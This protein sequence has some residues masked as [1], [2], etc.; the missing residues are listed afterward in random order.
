MYILSMVPL[1]VSVCREPRRVTFTACDAKSP[2][3]NAQQTVLNA[4]YKLRTN[5]IKNKEKNVRRRLSWSR[6]T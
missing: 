4:F 6:S 2:F 1:N 3:A 5:F